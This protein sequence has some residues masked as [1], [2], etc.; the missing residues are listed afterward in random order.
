MNYEKKFQPFFEISCADSFVTNFKLS[1]TIRSRNPFLPPQDEE[2]EL[3]YDDPEYRIEKK[4][5]RQYSVAKGSD[6]FEAEFFKW[7]IS[8]EKD[9]KGPWIC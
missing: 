1:R 3:L 5:I 9:D 7:L 2:M 6:K 4:L 8:D